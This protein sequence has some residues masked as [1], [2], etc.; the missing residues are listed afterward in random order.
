[1]IQPWVITSFCTAQN[2]VKKCILFYGFVQR[3]IT[4]FSRCGQQGR[5]RTRKL[6]LLLWIYR[7][8]DNEK[9]DVIPVELYKVWR[10]EEDNITAK[11]RLFIGTVLDSINKDIYTFFPGTLS[12]I[13]LMC[14]WGKLVLCNTC[15]SSWKPWCQYINITV[16]FCPRW[17][18]PNRL[19]LSHKL[20]L[21]RQYDLECMHTHFAIIL[22]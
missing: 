8:Q 17:N 9:M 11:G 12:I 13:A 10:L 22:F 3:C 2:I 18:R 6:L 16:S 4:I 20:S 5:L 14:S 21:L 15:S 7:T 1:M 19:L